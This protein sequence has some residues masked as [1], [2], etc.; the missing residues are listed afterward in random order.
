MIWNVWVN[1]TII[2]LNPL[3]EEQARTMARLHRFNYKSN[4]KAIKAL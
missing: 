1:G 4:A 2:N 3:N